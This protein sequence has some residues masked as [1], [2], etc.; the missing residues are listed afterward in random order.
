LRRRDAA[1]IVRAFM[2]ELT[3]LVTNDDGIHSPF[4]A[5]LV[6]ALLGHGRVCVVAPTEEKSWIGKAISRHRP[7]RAQPRNDLFGCPAWAVDGTPADCVNLGLGRLVAGAVGRIDMVASGI[8]MGSNAGLPLILASGTVGGAL[9]GACHGLHALATSI[10]L[11]KADFARIREPGTRLPE[12]IAAMVRVVARR[13]AELCATIARKPAPKRFLVHN[14]NFPHTTS[15]ATPIE[16]TI[17]ALVRIGT[18]F[19]PAAE[20][21]TFGFTF[22]VGDELPSAQLTDRACVESGR[23]S[24]SILDFGRLGLSGGPFGE[25]PAA[26]EAGG[27]A[28]VGA[29]DASDLSPP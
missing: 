14:L 17:P 25:V 7:L 6:A 21:D 29:A 2:R 11:D 20:A 23:A 27:S 10:R 5:A 22:A 4:L 1:A 8:N 28:N 3:F 9:E 15:D 13:S 26:P 16:R 24:H 12:H 18:L 19:E